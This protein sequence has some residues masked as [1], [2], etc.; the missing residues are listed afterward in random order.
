VT[1]RNPFRGGFS[2]GRVGESRKGERLPKQST[3]QSIADAIRRSANLHGI[4]GAANF[5]PEEKA[6]RELARDRLLTVTRDR[7]L[8][9]GGGDDALA[10]AI[11]EI[12]P[13]PLPVGEPSGAGRAV[14]AN[15]LEWE[16]G[17]LATWETGAD[18]VTPARPEVLGWFARGRL[19]ELERELGV[20]FLP[21]DVLVLRE[22]LRQ[23]LAGE[24]SKLVAHQGHAAEPPAKRSN[25]GRLLD[26]A[27]IKTWM[28]GEGLRNADLA[29]ELK[30]SDRAV[31]SL[32]NNGRCHGE[33]AVNKL[34]SKMGLEDETELY[35]N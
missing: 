9:L 18:G 14:L 23:A 13:N 2:F 25:P 10:C 20:V 5:T 1:K 17:S 21:P 19:G 34:A 11:D 26:T 31:R 35:V 28:K 6:A 29:K 27:R 16:P 15:G 32:R 4:H 7:F 12:V 22:E 3:G 33:D 24:R 30:L 8:E